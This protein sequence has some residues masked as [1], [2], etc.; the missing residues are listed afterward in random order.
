M[1][2]FAVLTKFRLMD[3]LM[4]I[5]ALPMADFGEPYKGCINFGQ[6]INNSWMAFL[7]RHF[8]MLAC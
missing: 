3:I 7:A 1:T 2:G 8:S 5:K 6:I 4:A